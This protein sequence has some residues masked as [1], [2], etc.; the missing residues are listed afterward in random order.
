VERHD[1]V[2]LHRVVCCY[3]DY[4][5]LLRAAADHADRALVFSHPPRNLVTR[6]L[7]AA[8]NLGHRIRRSAFRAYVHD[9]AAMTEVAADDGRLRPTYRHRGLA[10]H[11]VGFSTQAA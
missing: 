10:W 1:V 2:L 9:P 11:V 6:C 8:E 4:Q 3:P 7:L 5:R